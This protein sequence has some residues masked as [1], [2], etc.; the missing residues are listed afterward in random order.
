[1]WLE[2]YQKVIDHY[3]SRM[4]NSLSTVNANTRISVNWQNDD[5]PNVVGSWSNLDNLQTLVQPEVTDTATKEFVEPPLSNDYGWGSEPAPQSSRS[6]PTY[7]RKN[8]GRGRG[9]R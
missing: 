2:K 7:G 9:P 5:V 1:M 4:K 3:D 6:Q 8:R